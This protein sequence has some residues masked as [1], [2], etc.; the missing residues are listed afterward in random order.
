MSG[1][2]NRNTTQASFLRRLH[3]MARNNRSM[4]HLRNSPFQNDN[5]CGFLASDRATHKAQVHRRRGFYLRKNV[6][7][8]KTWHRTEARC[9]KILR[10]YKLG[11]YSGL[12]LSHR[13]S[14]C[15]RIS[16]LSRGLIHVLHL[17][18]EET[19][20]I[21]HKTS[22]RVVSFLKINRWIIA[23]WFLVSRLLGSWCVISSHLISSHH[24]AD[25]TW[26]RIIVWE[27]TAWRWVSDRTNVSMR[28]EHPINKD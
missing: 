6:M 20:F 16:L 17:I 5:L 28:Q 10:R 4:I 12:L 26:C 19:R 8:R 11:I 3:M 7:L 9:L 15:K 23:R 2:E 14:D 21:I 22:L 27:R 25:S 24:I 18:Y 13:I 1:S